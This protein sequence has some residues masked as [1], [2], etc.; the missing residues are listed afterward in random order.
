LDHA[1]FGCRLWVVV[2]GCWEARGFH[3]G[4]IRWGEW[5]EAWC[6]WCR[7]RAELG[8]VKIGA[9]FVANVHGLAELTLGVVAVEDDTVDNDCDSLDHNLNDTADE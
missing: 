7:L 1:F 8:E 4:G 2:G 6:V 5:A 9:C 3:V